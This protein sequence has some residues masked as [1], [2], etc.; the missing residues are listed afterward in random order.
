MC[1]SF[2]S[3]QLANGA[4]ATVTVLAME[5]VAMEEQEVA[6][7][8][9]AKTPQLVVATMVSIRGSHAESHHG[10]IRHRRCSRSA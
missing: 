4:L 9:A 8:E 6:V 3:H 2:D 10:C 7:A 5:E 1:R